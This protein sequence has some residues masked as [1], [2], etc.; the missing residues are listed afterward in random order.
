M[1]NS[2]CTPNVHPTLKYFKNEGKKES[3]RKLFT[4]RD[5]REF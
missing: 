1:L 3:P 2:K 4:Y 5:L